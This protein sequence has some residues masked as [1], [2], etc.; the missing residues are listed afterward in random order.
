MLCMQEF[1]G[2]GMVPRVDP[3][4]SVNLNADDGDEIAF[5]N[6]DNGPTNPYLHYT[7]E[8][9]G[10]EGGGVRGGQAAQAQDGGRE[11]GSRPKSGKIKSSS[12]K[13]SSSANAGSGASSTGAGGGSSSRPRSAAR[14]RGNEYEG[15]GGGNM[16]QSEE[17]YGRSSRAGNAEPEMSYPKARG[18]VDK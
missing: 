13:T 15:N 7:P 16:R 4:L 2:P 10:N 17:S 18:L 11:K 6:S 14:R 12:S 5:A 1:E 9:A 8:G 3:I